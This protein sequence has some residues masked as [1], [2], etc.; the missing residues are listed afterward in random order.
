MGGG[1][2]RGPSGGRAGAGA[3][4]PARAVIPAAQSILRS[5][6]CHRHRRGLLHLLLPLLPALLLRSLLVPPRLSLVLR[7]CRPGLA[8]VGTAA[9]TG[10]GQPAAPP[11]PP[12]APQSPGNSH[13]VPCTGRGQR[14]PSAQRR[15]Q[16]GHCPAKACGQG[17]PRGVGTVQQLLV[18]CSERTR[19]RA[20][21]SRGFR[22]GGTPAA[23]GRVCGG[24]RKRG[25]LQ[26]SAC[27]ARLLRAPHLSSADP[28]SPSSRE[29]SSTS[30]PR[31]QQRSTYVTPP[32]VSLHGRRTGRRVKQA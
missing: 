27:H 10:S 20:Q 26:A 4:A 16:C 7:S 23:L 17:V 24:A 9:L 12:E 2:R 28:C 13:S 8:A 19:R 22:Q 30:S 11:L 5:R 18:L 32:T 25:S 6:F 3:A 1:A 21:R 15:G 31:Q 29:L 14:V